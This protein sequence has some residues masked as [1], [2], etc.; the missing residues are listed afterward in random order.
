MENIYAMGLVIKEK[1]KEQN[2]TQKELAEKIGVSDKAVSKWERGES[3]PD[4]TLIPAIAVTLS[5]SI[6]YLMTGRD[7][8]DTAAEKEEVFGEK[9]S[10]QRDRALHS[11]MEIAQNKVN[12]LYTIFIFILLAV[13]VCFWFVDI[14]FGGF[15][16][17]FDLIY[18]PTV[19]IFI[20]LA[21]YTIFAAVMRTKRT[22][23]KA[24]YGSDIKGTLN[25][26]M[27]I[28]V[29]GTVFMMIY[30][31]SSPTVRNDDS[32]IRFVLGKVQFPVSDRYTLLYRGGYNI[33][34]SAIV[35]F[36]AVAAATA[37]SKRENAVGK[38]AITATVMCAVM[39]VK[40]W[41]LF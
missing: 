37:F 35:Y 2:L 14:T 28:L 38:N 26:V 36:G 32:I 11:A 9:C 21:L 22:A 17:M 41:Q 31:Y 10:V 13:L 23:L 7:Y 24:A 4:V 15:V 20:V 30:T 5:V 6:D 27:A 25:V 12:V 16:R 8:T 34:I 33:S 39:A 29:I 1:R 40:K 19:Y 3:L 18:V